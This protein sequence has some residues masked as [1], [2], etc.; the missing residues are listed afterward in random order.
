MKYKRVKLA[1]RL[2]NFAANRLHYARKRPYSD[3]MM[4]NGLTPL[5]NFAL[6]WNKKFLGVTKSFY[7]HSQISCIQFSWNE[8]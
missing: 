7:E 1:K 2:Y 6:S 4:G 8:G 5:R 3:G